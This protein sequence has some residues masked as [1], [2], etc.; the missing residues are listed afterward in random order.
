MILTAGY[1]ERKL[2]PNTGIRKG[3]FPPGLCLENSEKIG[4]IQRDADR[5]T[6]DVLGH[7]LRLGRFGTFFK[8]SPE[9]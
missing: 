2:M 5:S 6:S 1:G 3:D 7:F 8:L 4:V 9:H